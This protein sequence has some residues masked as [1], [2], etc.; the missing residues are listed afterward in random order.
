L[1]LQDVEEVVAGIAVADHEPAEILPEQL[2]G[3]GL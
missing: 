1:L 2:L 3:R